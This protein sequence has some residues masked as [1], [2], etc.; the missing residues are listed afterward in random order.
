VL[1]GFSVPQ[2]GA[3]VGDAA[4]AAFAGFVV[5]CGDLDAARLHELAVLA[6]SRGCH[7][8]AVVRAFVRAIGRREVPVIHAAG[9]IL[10]QFGPA[11]LAAVPDLEVQLARSVVARGQWFAE[12]GP[13]LVLDLAAHLRC[14]ADLPDGELRALPVDP[15]P[16]LALRALVEC[17]HRGIGDPACLRAALTARWGERPF[18]VGTEWAQANSRGGPSATV[19]IDD[20]IHVAA[21]LALVAIGAGGWDTAAVRAQAAGMFGVESA[22]VPEFLR[23]ARVAGRLGEL[24]DQV[25]V[26]LRVESGSPDPRQLVRK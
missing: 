14:G 3:A 23:Q 8:A 22:A 13:V 15:D 4:Q 21:A 7:G 1:C 19:A 18:E 11:A 17:V 16:R 20:E 24:A 12:A 9:A 2:A 10:L 26:R 25:E 5:G 6:R